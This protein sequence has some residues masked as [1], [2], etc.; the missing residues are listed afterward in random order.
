[1]ARKSLLASVTASLSET[2]ERSPS[3]IRSD[4]ARR[5]ASRAMMQSLDEIAENALRVL[6]GDTMVSLDPNLLDSSFVD[7]R[8]GEDAEEYRQ[9]LEAIKQFGQSSPILVRPHPE[10]DGRYMVVFGHRRTK[11]ARDLGI[12]VKAVIKPLADIEHVIAQGQENTARADLT[13]IEKALFAW[14]LLSNGMTK[15]TAK[16]ALSIDDSLLSRMLSVAETVPMGVIMALGAARGV[17]RDR[18]EELKRLAAMPAYSDKAVEFVKTD[19]FRSSDDGF[20]LLL[21]HLKQ[22]KRPRKI[23]TRPPEKSWAP[24]DGSV[25]VLSKSTPKA[26][27]VEFTNSD[28]KAFGTWITSNLDDLYETFRRMKTEN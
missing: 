1:M 26:L 9:L 25:C 3:A 16:A 27:M 17:G 14:K 7:D 2:S 24:R 18:W 22:S 23:A 20:N 6:E 21:S 28:G 8:L 15:D 19:E 11:V 13:F 5:G 4:Y 10:L 12:E